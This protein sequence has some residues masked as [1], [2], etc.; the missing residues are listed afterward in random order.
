V[1]GQPDQAKSEST[2]DSAGATHCG[3]VRKTNEDAFVIAMLQRSLLIQDAN[4]AAGG[5]FAGN[6]AGTLLVVADGMGGQ[7]GGDVASKVAIETVVNHLL[8]C[9]PWAPR[10]PARGAARGASL[11]GVREEL[12]T[13]MVEGDATVK[14]AGAQTSTPRMGTTLTMALVLGPI[15]YVAHV[16]DSRA[17]LLRD[18]Q[19][20]RLTRDHTLAQK[21]AE[22]SHEPIDPE[23]QLHHILWNSLGASDEVPE[24]EIQKLILEASDVL[25]LCSDGLTKHL[26][27]PQ[28]ANVLGMRAP[29]N[30]RCAMLIESANSAGGTDNITAVV[31]QAK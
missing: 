14:T 4:P 19:L 6:S 31:A 21:L 7:G 23:S 20:R 17:Y 3:R 27:D 11:S 25:L 9:M 13:A 26:T 18:G 29:A 24:P 16:G 2:L 22:E 30:E 8:N 15:A 10:R 28:I 5:W 12:A 1:P